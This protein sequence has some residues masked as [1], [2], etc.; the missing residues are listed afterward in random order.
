MIHLHSWQVGAGSEQEASDLHYVALSI[1]LQEC[2]H[3][4]GWMA[5]PRV[6]DTRE[7]KV[8]AS[9][10][11]YDQALEVTHHHF[12]SI[13]LVTQVIVFSVGGDCIRE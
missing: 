3:D 7:H 11:F 1:G 2:P 8:E 13:L 5:F 4:M 12:H 10:V 6:N 9:H